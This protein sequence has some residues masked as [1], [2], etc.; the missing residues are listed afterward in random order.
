MTASSC[1]GDLSETAERGGKLIIPSFALGR[2]EELLYWIG[3]LEERE[4]HPGA[5]GVTSTARWRWR[6][7]PATA[8]G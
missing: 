2:V 8:S 1:R 4:A 5:A 7:S 3:R 6:R